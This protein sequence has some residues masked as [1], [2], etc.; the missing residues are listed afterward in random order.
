MGGSGWAGAG[1][2]AGGVVG[3][4]GVTGYNMPAVS[5]KPLTMQMP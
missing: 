5:M 3:V 1:L 2:A 4:V